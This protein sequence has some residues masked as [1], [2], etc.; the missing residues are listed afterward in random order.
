[1]PIQIR[2]LLRQY[3]G[4]MQE[5]FGAELK[6]VILFGSYA[7]GDFTEASDVDIMILVDAAED[8]IKSKSRVLSDVTFDFNLDHDIMIMPIVK[9][10]DHFKYW[11]QADP[12]YKNIKNEGIDLYVA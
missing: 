4:R 8:T 7:R 2:D 12:F 5:I 11:L 6:A 3:V 10:M 1:M 9:N